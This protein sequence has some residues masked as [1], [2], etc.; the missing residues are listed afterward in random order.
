MTY[1]QIFINVQDYNDH[2]PYFLQSSYSVKVNESTAV[3]SFIL[4][5]QARDN[6]IGEN[7]RLTYSIVSG[8][9]EV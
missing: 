5:L 9:E 4:Q 2:S 3:N 7:A 1:L 6:D 8:N